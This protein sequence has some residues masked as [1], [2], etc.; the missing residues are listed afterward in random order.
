M[1]F[2]SGLVLSEHCQISPN[3]F[4][5]DDELSIKILGLQWEAQED[6]FS[7][8]AIPDTRPCT[9]RH[10]LSQVARIYDPLGFLAPISLLLKYLIQCLWK[11]K[12]DWDE[13]PP[14]NIL[15]LWS[16]FVSELPLLAAVKIPRVVIPPKVPD[17]QLHAFYDASQRGY[18]VVVYVRAIVDNEVVVRMLIAKSK[19][20]P[21]HSKRIARLELCG[22]TLLAKLVEYVKKTFHN[23]L[24]FPFVFAW[25]D[26]SIVLHWLASPPIRWSTFVANRVAYIQN[27]VPF[28]SWRHVAGVKNPADSPS[29][30][31]LPGELM[32]ADQWWKG[33]EFLYSLDEFWSMVPSRIPAVEDPS[34]LEEAKVVL[35]VQPDTGLFTSLLERFSSLSVIQRVVAHVLRFEHNTRHFAQRRQGPFTP[36]E[37]QTALMAVVKD[38]QAPAFARNISRI[39]RGKLPSYPLRPLSPFVDPSGVFRVGG[40]LHNAVIPFE[41]KHPAL[42]PQRHRLTDLV[43][44]QVHSQNCHPGISTKLYLLRQNFWILSCRRAVI[45]CRRGCTFCFRQNPRPFVPSM[46]N[47]P[48]TR[49]S[50]VKPFSC[51]GVDYAGPFFVTPMRQRGVKFY[52]AYL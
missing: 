14:E 17:I 52:R 35:V 18:S 23:L 41:T 33:P 20:A 4:H 45:R 37:L 34:D 40:R 13:P 9:K 47:L 2:G 32:S 26:A 31:L 7:F 12:V 27:R 11:L 1:N 22:A 50:Q 24:K 28:E 21:L 6:V 30:G 15:N 39:L 5:S 10:I 25:S 42:L 43:I 16:R 46:G 44:D 51:S 38:V 49:I 29:R 36:T 48:V 3:V 8:T 19:V